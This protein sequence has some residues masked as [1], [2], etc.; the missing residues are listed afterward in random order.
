MRRLLAA[1]TFL[2]L[3]SC[4]GDSGTGGESGTY[5]AAA[6]LYQLQGKLNSPPGSGQFSGT[7]VLG[8]TSRAQSTLTG[9][10]NVSATVVGSTGKY[11]KVTYAEVSEGGYVQFY[12]ESA[13]STNK[14]YFRG[15][16]SGRTITGT[17]D[18]TVNNSVYFGTFTATR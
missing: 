14:F 16:L 17:T 4:G 1:I 2:S 13:T 7:L 6:G 3:A 15:Q 10:A 11:G 9:S 5:P 18:L 12:L 8:Q